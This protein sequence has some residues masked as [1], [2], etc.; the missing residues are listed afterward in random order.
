MLISGNDRMSR[1]A[2]CLGAAHHFLLSEPEAIRIVEAQ[3]H[4]I[5]THWRAVCEEATLAEADRNLFW[6]RQFL[7]PFAFTGLD[8][9]AASLKS[10]ADEIWKSEAR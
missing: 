3:L 8:G 9:K 5:A 2:T 6:G 10:L 1:I 4:G 7:N